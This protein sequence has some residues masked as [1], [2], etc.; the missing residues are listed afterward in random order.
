MRTIAILIFLS[1]F[2][3]TFGQVSDTDI[4]NSILGKKY[5]EVNSILDSLGVWY[6]IHQP[7]KIKENFKVY[8]IADGDGTVK[9]FSLNLKY[10]VGSNSNFGIIEEIVINYSHHSREQIEDASKITS[11]SSIHIGRYSTDVIFKLK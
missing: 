1:F 10:N 9:V 5:Y 2:G 4:V 3:N 8:S 11:N 6:H 7:E